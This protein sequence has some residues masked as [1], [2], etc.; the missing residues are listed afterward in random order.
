M[1]KATTSGILSFRWRYIL[2]PMAILLLSILLSA[3]FYHLLPS[4]VA[5]HFKADGSPDRWLS[6]NAIIVWTLVPQIILT[7]VAGGLTWGITRLGIRFS[8]AKNAKEKSE[9]ILLLIGNM[10]VLPQVIICFAM[11]DIFSYNSYQ[12]HIMPLWL[13]ALIIMVLGGITLGIMF[14]RI[15]R[16][17]LRAK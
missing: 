5:Y 17:T 14:I 6:R 16:Q 2:L 4:E 3:Y 12:I 15:I 11:L 13:F 1:T 10:I 8:Q 7:L 9:G